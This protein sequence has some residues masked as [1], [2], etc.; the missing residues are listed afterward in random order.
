LQFLARLIYVGLNCDFGL[1]KI[2]QGFLLLWSEILA[3]TQK[4][5]RIKWGISNINWCLLRILKSFNFEN[6]T[7]NP[8]EVGV[9]SE[10]VKELLELGWI[11]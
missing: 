4:E 1:E 6:E 5:P 11:V 8:R 2:L 3:T 7:I 9:V 10:F